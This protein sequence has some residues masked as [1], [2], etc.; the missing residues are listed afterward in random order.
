MTNRRR[1]ATLAGVAAVAG[2]AVTATVLS[3]SAAGAASAANSSAYGIAGAGSVPISKHG[4]AVSTDGASHSSTE[5]SYSSSDGTLAV[6][7]IRSTAGA[8]TATSNVASVHY[9]GGKLKITGA[10]AN[11]NG[12]KTSGG[13]S[14]PVYDKKLFSSVSVTHPAATKNSDGSVTRVGVVVTI[15][16]AGGPAETLTVA[17]ATCAAHPGS[18]PTSKPPTSK[19]PTQSPTATTS[20]TTGPTTGPTSSPTNGPSTAPPPPV[21]TTHLPVTG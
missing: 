18:G 7:G 12:G 11:C 17:S 5:S 6:T 10:Y 13:S 21:T 9:L 8:Y 20:P 1:T 15:K 4:A 16:G 2:G 3:L 19:P 14:A